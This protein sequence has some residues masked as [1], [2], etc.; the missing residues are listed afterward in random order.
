MAGGFLNGGQ[1]GG[2]LHGGLALGSSSQNG[3]ANGNGNGNGAGGVQIEEVAAYT[4]QQGDTLR[5]RV[6]TA[7]GECI[8]VVT[9]AKR[10]LLVPRAGLGGLQAAPAAA[11]GKNPGAAQNTSALTPEQALERRRKLALY[12]GIGLG[13]LTTVGTIIATVIASKEKPE[14]MTDFMAD[15]TP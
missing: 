2:L 12:A 8:A 5:G 6:Q 9:A 3:H 14:P 7:A 13:L 4:L 10:V 11:G 1:W 15:D